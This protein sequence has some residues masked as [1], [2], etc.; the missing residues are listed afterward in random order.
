MADGNGR[1]Y[2][3]GSGRGGDGRGDDG[4]ETPRGRFGI[5][6]PL[7]SWLEVG[8][9]A[10][11][12]LILM[13]FFLSARSQTVAVVSTAIACALSVATLGI[14]AV[15]ALSSGRD[16]QDGGRIGFWESVI[17]SAIAVAL[18]AICMVMFFP[19]FGRFSET[20][21]YSNTE[22]LQ[23]VAVFVVGK[24]F[25]VPGSIQTDGF[26]V[27]APE[28]EEV[29]PPTVIPR[30]GLT[31]VGWRYAGVGDPDIAAG[32]PIYLD[33]NGTKN[34]SVILYA[35]FV[36]ASGTAYCACGNMEEGVFDGASWQGM[37]ARN[38][39]IAFVP[40][41]L[42]SLAGLACLVRIVRHDRDGGDLP[43]STR[44]AALGE[45]TG[46]PHGPDGPGGG[47]GDDS[48]P[49]VGTGDGGDG[50][51]TPGGEPEGHAHASGDGDLDAPEC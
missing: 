25:V 28:G 41:V 24:D 33:A 20:N 30:P 46:A 13:A 34:N 49:A 36:D 32:T 12:A 23:C 40:V 11:V 29:R 48:R 44:Q 47:S 9:A 8:I 14:V 6:A 43:P 21:P 38:F 26:V 51:M 10:Q 2:D 39:L 17:E 19:R 7:V 37:N 50:G 16:G 31:F 27:K 1:G 22:R 42:A 4:R 35:E 15:S 3:R 45:A 5:K 18:A